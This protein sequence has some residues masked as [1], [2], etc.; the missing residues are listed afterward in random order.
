[1]AEE[2][3]SEQLQYDLSQLGSVEQ[4]ELAQ[5]DAALMRVEA[6]KYG[7]CRD[8]GE[9]IDAS[10]LTAL[11]FALECADCASRREEAEASEREAKKGPRTMVPE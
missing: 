5:I 8:C 9:A 3:Q 7:I 2:S 11:P 4:R 10:R 1:M 6:G